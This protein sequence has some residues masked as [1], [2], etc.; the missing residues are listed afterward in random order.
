MCIC[1]IAEHA[2]QA[3]Q[4]QRLQTSSQAVA[5]MAF[6][7]ASDATL[8]G[9]PISHTHRPKMPMIASLTT[10]WLPTTTSRDN[11]EAASL[12]S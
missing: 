1:V 4:L 3:M 2:K 5:S 7:Q 11:I 8:F 9:S 10:A 6:M 12:D